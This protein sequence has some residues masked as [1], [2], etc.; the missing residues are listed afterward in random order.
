MNKGKK[1]KKVRGGSKNQHKNYVY[2]T[3]YWQK[4]I[5]DYK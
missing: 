5:L 1:G 3:K 4:A 2:N